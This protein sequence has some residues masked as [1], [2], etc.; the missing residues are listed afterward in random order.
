MC[1]YLSSEVPL[2]VTTLSNKHHAKCYRL[3]VHFPSKVKQSLAK[4]YAPTVACTSLGS[5]SCMFNWILMTAWKDIFWE[6]GLNKGPCF[7]EALYDLNSWEISSLTIKQEE[8]KAQERHITSPQIC[9]EAII[10]PWVMCCLYWVH[11]MTLKSFLF[12]NIYCPY[13]LFITMLSGVDPDIII[14]VPISVS[15]S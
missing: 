3:F 5:L 4:F 12:R 8:R 1:L 11:H 10:V 9:I 13:P 2:G 15:S 6:K 7:N 14:H